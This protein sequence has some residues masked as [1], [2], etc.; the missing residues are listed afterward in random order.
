MGTVL[1]L[2]LLL[3]FLCNCIFKGLNFLN[4]VYIIISAA[5]LGY[6]IYYLHGKKG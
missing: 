3:G 2:L 5:I 6:S 1:G 4:I